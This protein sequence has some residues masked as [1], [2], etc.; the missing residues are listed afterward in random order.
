MENQ[1]LKTESQIP[2]LIVGGIL[3][4]VLAYIM[5]KDERG[6]G[7]IFFFL[8]IVLPAFLYA[9]FLPTIIAKRR[10]HV[11]ATAIFM[12]NLLL[13][14]LLIPWV[15]AIVWAYKNDAVATTI[16][17]EQV[18]AAVA[19]DFKTCPYCAEQVRMEAIKCRYCHS[20]L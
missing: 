3:M 15:I 14:W 20:D 17:M 2:M 12:L 18:P 8:F 4:L 9:Y 19:S 16:E 1:K 13:G 11:N 6:A 10:K 5:I 7:W